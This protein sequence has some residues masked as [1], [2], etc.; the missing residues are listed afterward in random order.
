M[1]SRWIPSACD[2]EYVII[3]KTGSVRASL[4]S[5]ITCD[6]CDALV[7]YDWSPDGSQIVLLDENAQFSALVYVVPSNVTAA[8]YTSVRRE[9]GRAKDATSVNDKHPSR[10]P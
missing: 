8:N 1:P 7:G 6:G 10:R 5:D 9:V 4:Q 3:S 2:F